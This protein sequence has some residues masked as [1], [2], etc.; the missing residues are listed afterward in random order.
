MDRVIVSHS[1]GKDSTLAL[2]E[3]VSQGCSVEALLVS[4]N[5]GDQRSW[6]HGLSSSVMERTA[7]SLGVS[8]YPVASRGED[9]REQFVAA[10]KVWQARG[11]QH[12]IFG[13]IDI[14]EHRVWCQRVSAEAK[15]EAVH[16]LW[17]R[18]RV[19]LVESWFVVWVKPVF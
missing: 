14:E 15:V 13:D 2:H 11:A 3:V 18:G 9:Y 16:P 5:E 10:L 7:Q 19:S 4:V 17:G 6:F 1:F 8:L 12:C